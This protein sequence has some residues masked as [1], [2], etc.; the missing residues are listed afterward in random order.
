MSISSIW[1]LLIHLD[2]TKGPLP[3][4]DLMLVRDCLFHLSYQSILDFFKVFAASDIPLLLTTTH[5]NQD[6]AFENADIP[7]GHFRNIDLFSAPFSFSKPKKRILDN[8]AGEHT[9]DMCLFTRD[10]VAQAAKSLEAHL[11]Q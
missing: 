2:I 5:L 4:A 9:R 3:A 11:Q 6:N 7:T 8:I 10:Q 1:I